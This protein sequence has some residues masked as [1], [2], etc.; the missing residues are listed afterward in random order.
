FASV[1]ADVGQQDGVCLDALELRDRADPDPIRPVA[2]V[3]PEPAQVLGRRGVVVLT[4]EDPRRGR[5]RAPRT[6]DDD[7]ADAVL[8]GEEAEH[9]RE[10]R[11]LATRGDADALRPTGRALPESMLRDA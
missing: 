5:P 1:R 2:E 3:R 11:H 9:S 7:L 4:G 8:A 10:H 6:Q